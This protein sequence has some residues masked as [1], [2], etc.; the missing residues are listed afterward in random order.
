MKNMAAV[1]STLTCS[2]LYMNNAY[3]LEPV[4][5]LKDIGP[6]NLENCV[7][8]AVNDVMSVV[9]ECNGGSGSIVKSAWINY[10]PGKI[11]IL[12]SLVPGSSCTALRV[13][14]RNEVYGKC[15]GSNGQEQ[16]VVWNGVA[17]NAPPVALKP[18]GQ[19]Q[20]MIVT[21]VGDDFLVGQSFTGLNQQG[22]ST[23][24]LWSF[25]TGGA[26]PMTGIRDN[27]VATSMKESL[28]DYNWISLNCPSPM[29]NTDVKVATKVAGSST[30]VVT[31]LQI[32]ANSLYCRLGNTAERSQTF[33]SCR[34]P[35]GNPR[36]VHWPSI[37]STPV[38]LMSN[39]HKSAAARANDGGNG[40]IIF[41]DVNNNRSDALW[42]FS[43]NQVVNIVLPPQ[44]KIDSTAGLAN[45]NIVLLNTRDGQNREQGA[46]VSESLKTI[47]IGFLKGGRASRLEGINPKGTYAVGSATGADGKQYA[48][49]FS[50]SE[51]DLTTTSGQ[52]WVPPAVA[53]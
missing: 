24:T 38:V 2:F 46:F 28:T 52:V 30:Y 39:A 40:L 21:A 25:S 16:H 35:D 34:Y 8:Y 31:D 48:I 5:T 1:I 12:P 11:S 41:H 14:E 13:N 51:A 20:S 3:S 53:P 36:A 33:G 22:Q 32:P 43:Q 18:L 17:N 27:C 15:T 10:K 26:Q 19:D 37:N 44:S 23:V 9:G 4:P 49:G 29:G 7:A 6:P 42:N 47:S 45:N 50:T